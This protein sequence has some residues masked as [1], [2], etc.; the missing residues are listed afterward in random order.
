MDLQSLK[1]QHP[2][3]YAAA[4]KQGTDIER[5]RVTAHLT[6]GGASGDMKTACKA[7]EDGSPMTATLQ[8]TYMTAGMNRKD[9]ANRQE[10]DAG[11][12]AADDASS[13]DDLGDPAEDVL[14]IIEAK[15]GIQG[16]K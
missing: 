2:E 14:S 6:M 5:D 7:I 9:T 4:V 11:A 12:N 10:D 15:L 16:G 3:T 13:S 1:A 8:A